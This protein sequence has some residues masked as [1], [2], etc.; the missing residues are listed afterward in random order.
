MNN[1]ERLYFL[2][3]YYKTIFKLIYSN[4]R[5]YLPVIHL[6][7]RVHPL[8]VQTDL[9]TGLFWL[10]AN[11]VPFLHSYKTWDVPTAQFSETVVT[12]E[13]L[14]S[15][16]TWLFLFNSST[17]PIFFKLQLGTTSCSKNFLISFIYLFYFYK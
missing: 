11:L 12:L 17:V 10:F 13:H 9:N 7:A 4:I 8:T 14:R 2:F 5:T 16:N 1:L 6:G 3:F 15:N